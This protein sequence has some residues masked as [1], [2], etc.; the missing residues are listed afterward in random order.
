MATTNEPLSGILEEMTIDQVRE[1]DP[2][3]VVLPIGS[4]EPHGP[5]LPYGTDTYQIDGLCRRAV[6]QANRDGGQVLMYPALPISNNV[7]FQA[8]PFA[9][10]ITVRTLMKVILD[11]VEAL[12]QDGIRKIVISNG[13]GGNPA[14][15]QAA[16]REHVGRRRPGEGAFVCMAGGIW[17]RPEC[18]GLIEHPSAHA[19]EA[20][21]SQM[22]YLRPD[23]VHEDKFADNPVMTSMFEQIESGKVQ[24]VKP[25]HA[26]LPVSAGGE[27]R[28][29]SG[30]K[31][32]ILI[33]AG[34]EG[35]ARFLV[36]LSNTPMNDLFP[37]P[38]ND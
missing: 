31:G 10:R 30:E 26:Y 1:L 6:I 15:L 22:M 16:I 33:E 8:F 3:V 34:A 20:E 28:T 5:H 19:G 4:T 38:Q 13:H 32:E 24:C 29:S 18:K 11:I 36:Q 2:Q 35:L 21:T 9:C 17:E 27:T 37:Y 7:N 14:T 12:E 25:W 23:L